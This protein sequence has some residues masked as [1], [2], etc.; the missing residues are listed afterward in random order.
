M[1]SQT[2]NK[3]LDKLEVV[4]GEVL[5]T[6]EI[7]YRRWYGGIQTKRFDIWVKD[8]SLCIGQCNKSFINKKIEWCLSDKP[9]PIETIREW[10]KSIIP[11]LYPTNK[12]SS[13][14]SN[15][16]KLAERIEKQT[17]EYY[18]LCEKNKLTTKFASD[19][20]MLHIQKGMKNT[21]LDKTKKEKK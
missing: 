11:I 21:Y 7:P 9:V 1:K 16:L 6:L 12:N 4:V 20:L 2:R 17:N 18:K 10:L 8:N 5:Y 19:V 3:R 14:L 15:I 13:E